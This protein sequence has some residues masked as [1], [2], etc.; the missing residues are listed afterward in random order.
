MGAN[1]TPAFD[2]NELLRHRSF[3]RRLAHE[4]AGSQ[5]AED[6]EQEAWVAALQNPP[7]V[8][9]AAR[10]WFRTVLRHLAAR[11][12]R[13]EDRRLGREEQAAGPELSENPLEVAE[14][15]SRERRLIQAVENLAEP[16]RSAILLRYFEELSPLAIARRQRVPVATIKTRLRRGLVQLRERL[17]GDDPALPVWLAALGRP[18][19][20]NEPAHPQGCGP[21]GGRPHGHVAL[22]LAR[23]DWPRTPSG[24][25]SHRRFV[26]HARPERHCPEPAPL[27]RLQCSDC[28]D[29]R[30]P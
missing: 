5:G 28:S 6:L 16:Y 15:L 7:R 13:A 19:R 11:G 9:A 1:L 30:A 17:S 4:L 23:R 20:R 26:R 10:N 27:R 2:E 29:S 25:R 18:A 21:R 24:A 8:A 12:A 22:G 14:R 3:V